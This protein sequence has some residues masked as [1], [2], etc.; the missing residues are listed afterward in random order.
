M[1]LLD[2]APSMVN[3]E[4]AT[5]PKLTPGLNQA[6][7]VALQSRPCPAFLLFAALGFATFA[8]KTIKLSRCASNQGLLP[9][10]CAHH[11]CPAELLAFEEYTAL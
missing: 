6:A 1:R 3:Q 7:V 4:G 11:P 10:F 2:A 5:A 8:S 9:S